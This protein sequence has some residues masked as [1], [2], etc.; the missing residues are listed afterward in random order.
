MRKEIS[1]MDVIVGLLL[2]GGLV[3][4]SGGAIGILRFPDFYSRLHPAGKLDTA[5]QLLALSAIALYVLEA[6][7]LQ[8]ILT[9]AK[10][11]LIVLFVYITSPTATHAI[12]DAGIRAGLVPWE[13]RHRNDLAD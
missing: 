4:F 10:I 9:A 11:G 3:F 7:T 5:G 13:K 12:V 2:I 6:I 1:A 8:Q